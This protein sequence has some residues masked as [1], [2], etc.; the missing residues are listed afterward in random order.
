MKQLVAQDLYDA[1]GGIS[2]RHVM[3]ALP[4]SWAGGAPAAPR[5]RRT[6][7]GLVSF[8]LDNGWVAAVL[9]AVVAISVIVAIVLAGRGEGPVPPVGGTVESESESNGEGPSSETTKP[10]SA[11]LDR[12]TETETETES[13]SESVS[14]PPPAAD[15]RL[16]TT[17]ACT[18]SAS[19]YAGA[20]QKD[21]IVRTYRAPDGVTMTMHDA[22]TGEEYSRLFFS[23][24]ATLFY[25]PAGEW[26]VLQYDV[27][28]RDGIPYL[29]FKGGVVKP[30]GTYTGMESTEEPTWCLSN[31]ANSFAADHASV[32]TR[33]QIQYV[34]AR[35]Q[36]DKAMRGWSEILVAAS[37]DPFFAAYGDPT[38]DA[39]TSEV[40]E[41]L[42]DERPIGDLWDLYMTE[43][44]TSPET[45]ATT[46]TELTDLSMI[47]VIPPDGS[48]VSIPG[49][50]QFGYY[51]DTEGRQVELTPSDYTWKERILSGDVPTVVMPQGAQL[52]WFYFRA[53]GWTHAEGGSIYTYSAGDEEPVRIRL[54]PDPSA[55][56]SGTYFVYLIIEAESPRGVS[57]HK[58]YYSYQYTFRLIIDDGTFETE[59][60]AKGLLTP[61]PEEE[62]D[63]PRPDPV[64]NPLSSTCRVNVSFGG[65]SVQLLQGYI[66]DGDL[67]VSSGLSDVT[68]TDYV[69]SGTGAPIDGNYLRVLSEDPY[70]PTICTENPASYKITFQ[71]HSWR[72]AS[73]SYVIYNADFQRLGALMGDLVDGVY[74]VV[75]YANTNRSAP[76]THKIGTWT[77]EGIARYNI[78]FRLVVGDV[79]FTPPAYPAEE[80]LHAP[81]DG[82]AVT[83]N[84]GTTVIDEGYLYQAALTDESGQT[85]LGVDFPAISYQLARNLAHYDKTIT[86][87]ADTAASVV[88]APV[89]TDADRAVIT[90]YIYDR[91]YALTDFEITN[92]PDGTYYVLVDIELEGG[93]FTVDGQAYTG[94]TARY[95]VMLVL[96]IGASA[97]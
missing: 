41:N 73:S 13:E 77:L 86:I 51:Y 32:V 56:P 54:T 47:R 22:Q 75:I 97:S 36:I 40:M 34:R 14:V 96:C 37:T 61:I 58:D 23:G 44:E 91:A 17:V 95:Q 38:S 46:D 16:T 60:E 35:E 74:Y 30:T 19:N 70:L 18:A 25:T 6:S 82:L 85:A 88:L 8:F 76:G 80:K 64:L 57:K 48:A 68:D 31:P 11:P 12:E 79:D 39:L 21:V 67:T 43:Q 81:F 87:S 4:P 29:I 93:S 92:L 90:T 9:S 42:W 7:S 65:A 20:H 50:L 62:Y 45:E 2:D 52:E 49:D 55:L 53:E 3:D 5:A 59:T 94:G 72:P 26:A 66:Y 10:E 33:N 63:A 1:L 27:E 83:T 28:E 15:A 84:R 89:K 24:E 78:P 71:A 69:Y